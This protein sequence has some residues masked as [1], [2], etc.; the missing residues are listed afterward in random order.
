MT[1]LQINPLRLSPVSFPVQLHIND[2]TY[3][4]DYVTTFSALVD[5]REHAQPIYLCGS[6][7]FRLTHELKFV[8]NTGEL[9]LDK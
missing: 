9:L 6:K 7:R 1:T 8:T 4:Y 2:K 5:R 3:V